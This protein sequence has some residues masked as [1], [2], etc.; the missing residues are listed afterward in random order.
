MAAENKIVHQ[1]SLKTAN[2]NG[3]QMVQVKH[4]Y[5]RIYTCTV[6]IKATINLRLLILAILARSLLISKL[7]TCIILYHA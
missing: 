7:S 5:I 2:I 3:R 6:Y 4:T 1:V